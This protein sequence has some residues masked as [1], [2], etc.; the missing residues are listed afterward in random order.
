M[1]PHI[2]CIRCTLRYRQTAGGLRSW[3][4]RQTD[5]PSN[6]DCVKRT[7][8][9]TSPVSQAPVPACLVTAPGKYD[10]PAILHAFI[11]GFFLCPAPASL[12]HNAR[13]NRFP[14]R[15]FFAG[16]ERDCFSPL[17]AGRDAEVRRDIGICDYRFGILFAP[18]EPAGASMCVGENIHHLLHFRVDRD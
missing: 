10:G 9:R 5:I 12:T 17:C 1:P 3:R 7:Y 6:R 15:C 11:V 18:G 14:R 16:N 13:K 8:P 4:L 2:F